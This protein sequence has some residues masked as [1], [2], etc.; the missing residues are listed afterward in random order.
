MWKCGKFEFSCG[1]YIMGVLNVTPDSFS[2][3]G[4]HNSVE[5]AVA[6]A[7]RMADEGADIIDVGGE[8]TRP[9]S[10]PPSIEEELE[11]VLPVVSAL[12]A[13][14]MCVSVDTRHWEVAQACLAA[15]AHIINDVSGFR[16][17][18]MRRLVA[19]SDCGV[20]VMHMLGEPGTMQDSPR[21][22][23]VLAEVGGYL[24]RQAR[25]LQE[26]GVDP[27]RI[28]IDPGP[29]FG[30]TFE[31]NQVLI[32]H[33]RW[34]SQ[35]GYPLM[36]AVSRKSYI[37]AATGIE[38]PRERDAASA[39]CAAAACRE[40]AIV[41]RVHDVATTARTFAS[42]K[43]A[44]IALGSN[45]GDRC[46]QLDAAIA[47]LRRA[48]GVWVYSVSSYVESEPAYKED[49]APFANAVAVLETSLAPAE[50]LEL[51]HAIEDEQGRLR[52]E[53]NGPRTLDLDMLDYEGVVSADP[54]LTLPHPRLM[55]RDFVVTPLLELLDG[56]VLADGRAV[57]REQLSCGA[58]TG[59]LRK[60]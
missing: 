18:R 23:D 16:D 41:A 35:L 55:E 17:S 15:G 57:T 32:S 60:S 39:L 48:P 2:D 37:G 49:Q 56:Y 46:A 9:G 30:K 4:L 21:Y 28:C 27:Q 3:G 45:I 8:S 51:L 31:H 10:Q 14:G 44:V 13:R 58:V 52:L 24:L 25:L 19:G 22:D 11:R 1:H 29:G 59:V 47:A 5:L 53:A 43:R 36:V 40:G 26:E 7:K 6:H 33:T 42:S 50:L 12:V 54:R 34:L 38:L 20:V